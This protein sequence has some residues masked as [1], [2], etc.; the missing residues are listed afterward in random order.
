ML[1]HGLNLFEHD[2]R[3]VLATFHVIQIKHFKA[4]LR[5]KQ[6]KV[7]EYYHDV[8]AGKNE[9]LCII[10]PRKTLQNCLR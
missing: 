3:Q 7:G 8:Q 5:V 1:N 10:K 9:K 2:L 4:S 6:T